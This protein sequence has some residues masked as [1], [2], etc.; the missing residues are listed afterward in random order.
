MGNRHYFVGQFVGCGM[1]K[2]TSKTVEALAKAGSPGKTGDGDGLYF[3]VSRA[4]VTSWLFRY[5][6]AGKSREMGLG[7]YPTVPLAKARELAADHRKVRAAGNDPLAARDAEREAKREA[8]RTQEARR[9]TFSVLASDYM[10]AHGAAWS[11]SERAG[12]ANW[13][14]TLFL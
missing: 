10:A 6:L 13:S 5:M 14:C 3:Q 8:E 11:E 9:V 7:P 1:G 2:L 12:Y 4:G